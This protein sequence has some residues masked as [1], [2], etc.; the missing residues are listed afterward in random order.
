MAYQLGKV[1]QL[2]K[3]QLNMVSDHRG[4]HVVHVRPRLECDF[5]TWETVN[6]ESPN[7]NQQILDNYDQPQF[8]GL[9]PWLRLHKSTKRR[10]LPRSLQV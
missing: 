9:K 10:R 2:Q 5:D 7:K 6:E 1:V 4:H 3:S 8:Q